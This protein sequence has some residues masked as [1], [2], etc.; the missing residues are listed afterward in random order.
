MAQNQPQDKGLSAKG[1]YSKLQSKREPYITRAI[2]CA[3]LTIP[4]VFHDESD[5]GDTKFK[6]PYQSIGAR[7]VNNL[8]SKLALALFPPN[9][10]FFKL[11][12]STE[13]KQKLINTTPEQYEEKMQSI[14]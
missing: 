6:T 10:G 1:L 9:E 4:H 5:T 11:G 12:L 14:E 2:E 8:T 13:M 7:G 3:K